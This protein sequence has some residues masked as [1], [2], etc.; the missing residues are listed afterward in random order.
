MSWFLA[1]ALNVFK[2]AL[3]YM[4]FTGNFMIFSGKIGHVSNLLCC[5]V[6]LNSFDVIFQCMLNLTWHAN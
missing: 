4:I 5:S 6:C 2:S 3:I 1:M